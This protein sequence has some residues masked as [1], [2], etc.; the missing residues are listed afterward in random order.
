MKRNNTV[1][2]TENGSKAQKIIIVVTF[3]ILLAV[4]VP[5]LYTMLYTVPTQDDFTF[6]SW[7]KNYGGKGNVFLD[8]ISATKW[9]YANW[10]CGIPYVF[11]Q[12]IFNPLLYFDVD[13]YAY[14]IQL[15]IVFLFFLASLFFYLKYL[16]K[17]IFKVNN[18]AVV[19]V[20]YATIV[21][22]LLN[23]EVFSEIFW[24][25][26]GRIYEIVL[27]FAMLNHV[28][29]I[30]LCNA[31]GKKL[32]LMIVVT[33]IVGFITCFNYQIA[34]FL[35]ILW[36]I[37]IY[38][39]GLKGAKKKELALKTVPMLFMI[40]GGCISAFG[41]GNFVR[42]AEY[43][44]NS[45]MTQTVLW[46][47]QATYKI[48]IIFASNP[49]AIFT[50]LAFICLGYFFSRNH[51][52]K[53]II[54]MLL[55]VMATYIMVFPIALGQGNS[56]IHNRM[57]FFVGVPAYLFQM[58]VAFAA[59]SYIK[60][61]YSKV[62]S[63]LTIKQKL[64]IGSIIVIIAVVFGGAF[65]LLNNNSGKIVDN[66]LIFTYRNTSSAVAQGKKTKDLYRAILQSDEEYYC[67]EDYSSYN[68]CYLYRSLYIG[69]DEWWVN[70]DMY[71]YFGTHIRK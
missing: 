46:T 33:S 7:M 53:P 68:E 5:F 47:M 36:I 42:Q 32:P 40:I 9:A 67:I 31:K 14:G 63:A 15:I 39:L 56:N 66:A 23:C 52:K 28:L 55:G 24:W 62:I 17:N 4:I 69:D 20:G 61:N 60:M 58:I 57:L 19:A 48:V 38:C 3:A 18:T 11:I 71:T 8:A 50:Y 1:I 26:T 21:I 64:E 70:E 44:N 22:S 54:L 30:E 35:G 29:I 65:N 43:T 51:I 59:G 12:L 27:I 16:A 2:S 10:T 49:L 25:Y 45:S 34:V 13:S 41:A 37:H 6:Y